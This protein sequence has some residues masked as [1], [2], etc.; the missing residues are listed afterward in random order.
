MQGATLI[1]SG[2]SSLITA[3][4]TATTL[5]V[6]NTPPTALTGAAGLGAT[7]SISYVPAAQANNA[8]LSAVYNSSLAAAAYATGTVGTGGVPS[9]IITGVST[10]FTVNM[11]GGTITIGS[12]SSIIL[13]FL[14]AQS[15]LVRDSFNVAAGTSYTIV[16]NNQQVILGKTY[17]S[18]YYNNG[19]RKRLN[20]R[21]LNTTYSAGSTSFTC[22]FYIPLRDIHPLFLNQH[23]PTQGIQFIDRFYLCNFINPF[24]STGSLNTGSDYTNI[25]T[26]PNDI[27]D[28]ITFTPGQ[29][30]MYIKNI[31]LNERI[32]PLWAQIFNKGVQSRI[33]FLGCYKKKIL[34]TTL[35]DTGVPNS[36]VFSSISRLRRLWFFG[37]PTGAAQSPYVPINPTMQLT[38]IT[39]QIN[40]EPAQKYTITGDRANWQILRNELNFHGVRTYYHIKHIL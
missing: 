19:M 38:T 29:A 26:N 3:Y 21:I 18:V 5:L 10:T 22:V 23:K 40:T 37:I 35:N 27:P 25:L 4:L 14:S 17:S 13:A 2:Y 32:A 20:Y 12:Q 16:Y 15:L 28:T 30:Q 31:T 7:W 1:A 8:N 34:T 36:L 6:A 33:D 11:V 39:I 9:T 24:S